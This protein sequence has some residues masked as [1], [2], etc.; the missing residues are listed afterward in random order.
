MVKR[1]FAK[2]RK[3]LERSFC[4]R[5]YERLSSFCYRELKE[6]YLSPA[7]KIIFLF[8]LMLCAEITISLGAPVSRSVRINLPYATTLNITE[9]NPKL[10]FL[11][12]NCAHK[13]GAFFVVA[14]Q[15]SSLLPQAHAYN[16]IIPASVKTA[17]FTLFASL[18]KLLMRDD[19]IIVD[20]EIKLSPI[21]AQGP[22]FF[23]RLFTANCLISC[24]ARYLHYCPIAYIA[25]QE[26]YSLSAGILAVSIVFNTQPNLNTYL[27]EIVY[28]V[29]RNFKFSA[30][31]SHLKVFNPST[32]SIFI[33]KNPP[34]FIGKILSAPEIFA[35][36]IFIVGKNKI[37]KYT[38]GTVLVKFKRAQIFLLRRVELIFNFNPLVLIPRAKLVEK[39][40]GTSP[41]TGLQKGGEKPIFNCRRK[42]LP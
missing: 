8:L 17:I 27:A 28:P 16:S 4:S 10:F 11:G 7:R 15:Y 33:F 30:F 5:F 19:R 39:R 31:P 3:I 22:P 35:K 36:T 32:H 2:T 37:S 41:S 13:A 24:L 23:K 20:T 21:K 38:F 42:C 34:L 26:K 18:T 25:R 1:Y 40:L 9:H 29:Y 6:N 12:K 14:L